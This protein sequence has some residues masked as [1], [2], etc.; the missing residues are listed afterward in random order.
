[1]S[2]E[3]LLDVRDVSRH[4]SGLRAVSGVSFQVAAG[5]VVGL[6]GPNGSGKSTLFN[7]ITG[8]YA[9]SSGSIYFRG[10]DLSGKPR[11][12]IARLGLARTFQHPRLFSSLSAEQNVV[13]GLEMPRKKPTL[14]NLLRQLVMPWTTHAASARE[15]L[16]AVGLADPERSASSLPFGQRRLLEVARRLAAAPSLLLLDEPTA[17]L[18]EAESAQLAELLEQSRRAGLAVL[19]VDH[20]ID[21]I[22]AVCPRVLVLHHGEL[23]A[24]GPTA[25]VLTDPRVVA[26]YLGQE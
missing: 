16:A 9:P 7:L 2:A 25:A 6:V 26:A 17:G 13:V 8:V 19:V 11:H 3:T 24:S 10:L 23:L 20:R 21:F 22:R 14:W 1:V 15:A 4:F 12:E 18:S 5:E